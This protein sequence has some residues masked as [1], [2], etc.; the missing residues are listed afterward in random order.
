MSTAIIKIDNEK[1]SYVKKLILKL[2]GSMEVVKDKQLEKFL[3]DQWM[4]KM[5]D[6]SESEPG[7]VSLAS[8]KKLFAKDGIAL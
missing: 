4:G 6:Q 8:M 7:E 2:K 1:L 3:E 5:I